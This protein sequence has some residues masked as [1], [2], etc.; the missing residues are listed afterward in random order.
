MSRQKTLLVLCYLLITMGTAAA[1]DIYDGKR[2]GPL[3]NRAPPD[4]VV[5]L[6]KYCWG[7][8]NAKLKGPKFNIQRESCGVYTNHFCQGMLQFNRSQNPMASPS[9]RRQYL[10]EAAGNIEYTMKGIKDFPGCYIRKHVAIMQKRVRMAAS[11]A[12]P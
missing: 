2:D 9:E 1:K 8:Y 7:Q 12:R 10:A 6:P 11:T 5:R 3:Y 4:E